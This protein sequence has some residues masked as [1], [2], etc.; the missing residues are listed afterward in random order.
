MHGS[1]KFREIVE[2]R[3][4]IEFF[5]RCMRQADIE[6]EAV[7]VDGSIRRIGKKRLL[8]SSFHKFPEFDLSRLGSKGIKNKKTELRVALLQKTGSSMEFLRCFAMQ[9]GPL[10]ALVNVLV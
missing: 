7:G 1:G 8:R 9:K 2:R 10:E 6:S 5:S 4:H 3:S